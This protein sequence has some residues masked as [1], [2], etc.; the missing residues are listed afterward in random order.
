MIPA[1]MLAAVTITAGPGSQPRTAS[2][3]RQTAPVLPPIARALALPYPASGTPQPQIIST[4]KDPNVPRLIDLADATAVAL[5]RVPALI[6]IVSN[7]AT[8][9]QTRAAYASS[10]TALQS[11]QGQYRVGVSTLPALIQSQTTLASSA[12]NIVNAIYKLR[13]AESDLR[14]ALG[15]ILQ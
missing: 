11:T 2:R 1:L 5:I 9:D 8:L 3:R 15:T 6:T 10:V 12:V 14:F 7:R 13:L 4:R